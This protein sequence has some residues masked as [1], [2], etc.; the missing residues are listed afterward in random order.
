MLRPFRYTCA[1]LLAFAAFAPRGVA[2]VGAPLDRQ[3]RVFLDCPNVNCF[4]EYAIEQIPWVDFVRDRAVADVH[5]LVTVQRTGGG[6]W[7][8]TTRFIGR[9]RF[10]GRDQTML[11]LIPAG[12]T[13]DEDRRHFVQRLK[14]I[15]SGY[16]AESSAAPRL[17][18]TWS[19]EAT[20]APAPLPQ[21]DPWRRWVFEVGAQAAVNGESSSS[22]V[23]FF[24]YV[25]ADRVTDE[26]KL[27][28]S[29]FGNSQRQEFDIDDTTTVEITRE[30][31]GSSGLV[32]RS[33]SPHWSAGAYGGWRRSSRN[34][35][36]ASVRF[37]PAIEYDVFPYRESTSRLLTFIYSIGP[38][39]YDYTER[40][41]FGQTSETLLQHFLAINFVATQPWGDLDIGVE[42]EHFIAG[43]NGET[44]WSE[45]QYS[46]S[47]GGGIE[48]RL[49]R[50]LSM[51]I[52]GFTE[53]VRD[54]IQLPAGDLT[55]EEI[56][57]EQRERA[58][59]YRYFG[60]VGLSYEFGSIFSAV[61]NPRFPY[62]D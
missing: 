16:A 2:Q 48:V 35:Y 15:L 43:L 17:G 5:A 42:L 39:Y 7:E 62:L 37:G 33:L 27:S 6:G 59:N 58:T 31:F 29:T 4:E 60:R 44:A 22:E 41:I 21:A 45:P 56:L 34:N 51:E 23:E 8:V 10:A 12:S 30:S 14:L 40:T 26:W 55:P 25:E 57:T 32:V 38:R 24:G 20:D 47:I 3:V 53:M 28:L 11:F 18:V 1:L 54:Q 46:A 19:D 50:G 61:V 52:H 9:E 49:I 13:D 36:D